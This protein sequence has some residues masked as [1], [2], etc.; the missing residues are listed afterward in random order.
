VCGVAAALEGR[1]GLDMTAPYRTA[2]P[3]LRSCSTK[4]LLAG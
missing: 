2:A 4:G 3:E 1:G